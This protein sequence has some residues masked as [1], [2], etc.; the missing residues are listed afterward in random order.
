MA[1]AAAAVVTNP[2][3]KKVLADAG[4]RHPGH[5]EFLGELT[6][7]RNPVMMLACPG[8]RVVPVTVHA[9]LG[10]AIGLLTTRAI[11]AASRTTAEALQTD[12]AIA[13]PRLAIA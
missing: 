6:G 5:T 4:F 12:F 8:L 9:P 10:K 7:A 1:G 13:A 3:H 2:I 11:V